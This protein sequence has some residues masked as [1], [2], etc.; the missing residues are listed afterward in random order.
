MRWG[1]KV[2]NTEFSQWRRPEP[3]L[4]CRP[5][6]A[7]ADWVN[8][9]TSKQ[10]TKPRALN[11]KRPSSSAGGLSHPAAAAD[12][13]AQSRQFSAMCCVGQRYPAIFAA[14]PTVAAQFRLGCC[15]ECALYAILHL[16]LAD[17][18]HAAYYL[19][20]PDGDAG[21]LNCS[22]PRLFNMFLIVAPHRLLCII[23]TFSKSQPL[24]APYYD[25]GSLHLQNQYQVSKMPRFS[26]TRLCV[27]LYIL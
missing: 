7:T 11:T 1:R 20:V 6:L 17:S 16:S 18:S 15:L 24:G 25:N 27:A 21:C 9:S 22:E 19:S 14:W 12:L 13:K 23:H 8:I 2:L 3:L 26:C 4:S 5:L 10:S